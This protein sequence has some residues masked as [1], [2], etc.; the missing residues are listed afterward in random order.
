M[1]ISLLFFCFT[2]RC[3]QMQMHRFRATNPGDSASV[4]GGGNRGALSASRLS[5]GAGRG[6]AQGKGRAFPKGAEDPTRGGKCRCQLFQQD[7][8]EA[9][10]SQGP[11][12]WKLLSDEVIFTNVITKKYGY[13]SKM[14]KM[15]RCGKSC[16]KFPPEASS[17]DTFTYHVTSTISV[18]W[19][20]C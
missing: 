1:H 5:A 12:G 10:E 17:S 14:K 2:D 7:G 16:V 19:A 9:R 6:R 15:H 13:L 20:T 18:P 8:R 4:A 3:E 11:T